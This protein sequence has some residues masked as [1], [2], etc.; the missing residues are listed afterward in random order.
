ME[1][2]LP[3]IHD[4][5]ALHIDVIYSSE[6]SITVDEIEF[7]ISQLEKNHVV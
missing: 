5:D 4:D 6:M 7:A 3:P 2:S 1:Q